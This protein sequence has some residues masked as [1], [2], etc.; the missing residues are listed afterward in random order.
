VNHT[1]F[2]AGQVDL[3]QTKLSLRVRQGLVNEVSGDA[4]VSEGRH[5]VYLDEVDIRRQ[6]EGYMLYFKIARLYSLIWTQPQK[7]SN[8]TCMQ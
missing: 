5:S 4:C 3:G 7:P 6:E 8:Q 1:V 2:V